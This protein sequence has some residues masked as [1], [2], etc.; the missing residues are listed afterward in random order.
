MKPTKELLQEYNDLFKSMVVNKTP[1][2]DAIV[3]KILSERH[4]YEAV[5]KETGV[6]WYVIATIHNMEASLDF[7]KQLH[8]GQFWNQRTTW[9]PKGLGP[10]GSWHEAAVDAMTTLKKD[11][12]RVFGDFE[13]LQISMVCY[14]FESHNGW[15]YRKFH[16]HVKSPYLWSFSNHY[17][18]GKY[19]AD[20]K[21]SETAVSAQVGAMVIIKQLME[22]ANILN[23]EQSSEPTPIPEPSK[24]VEPKPAPRPPVRVSFWQKVKRFFGWG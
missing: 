9:V 24:P 19:V 7:R 12:Q 14:A 22:K 5:E 16:S 1:S 23:G 17:T 13:V 18:K 6:P 2:V 4:Q 11:L 3:K 15:G 8:N 21:W 10:W 20:G